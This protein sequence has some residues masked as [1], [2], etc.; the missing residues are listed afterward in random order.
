MSSSEKFELDNVIR[1][2]GQFGKF[3]LINYILIS[4]PLGLTAVYALT[5]VFTASDLNY[6]CVVPECDKIIDSNIEFNPKWLKYAVPFKEDLPV[7]CDRYT[8]NNS[9][10][11]ECRNGS[12]LT[13]NTKRCDEFVYEN[14]EKTILNEVKRQ[15]FLNHV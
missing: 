4:I 8:L 2:I 14:N 5:Y 15:N 9:R 7:Q 1:E 13:H 11:F 12:F 6:R 3:Q 10:E